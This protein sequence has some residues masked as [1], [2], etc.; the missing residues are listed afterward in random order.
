MF[1]ASDNR[2]PLRELGRNE[3]VCRRVL[4]GRV[5]KEARPHEFHPLLNSFIQHQK[6]RR[7]PDPRWLRLPTARK[8]CFNVL[9][10]MLSG[11]AV[12]AVLGCVSATCMEVSA[13]KAASYQC[14]TA[15]PANFNRVY[16]LSSAVGCAY[17][18][19]NLENLTM[20][21][22]VTVTGY[23]DTYPSPPSP[24]I[25]AY[26]IPAGANLLGTWDPQTLTGTGTK[27]S[28]TGAAGGTITFSNSFNFSDVL[29]AIQDGANAPGPRW[30]VF[31][32]GAVLAGT[33]LNWDYLTCNNGH[34]CGLA[35]DAASGL[36][37]WGGSTPTRGGGDPLATPLPAA[38]PLFA[39][40]LGALGLLGWRRKR[41]AK[42]S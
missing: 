37:V 26:P 31:D 19:G 2:G 34:A 13:S 21:S 9:L 24:T 6:R 8:W 7:I 40:S 36:L 10:W 5:E 16:E 14:P 17:G 30:A 20:T 35:T 18:A 4:A 38:L 39:T 27:V 3:L 42:A 15:N 32:V 12:A 29:V 22:G 1:S 11:V 33:V 28:F 41:K 23:Q 25:G